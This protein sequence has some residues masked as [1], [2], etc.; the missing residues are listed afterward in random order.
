MASP[1]PHCPHRPPCPGCPHFFEPGYPGDTARALGEFAAAADLAPPV[2]QEGQATGFRTRARLMVRGR[3]ASPKIGIFQSRSHRIA[4]IPNC[5]VHHPLIN[6]VSRSVKQAIRSTD[7]RPY[8]EGPHLGD[9]RAIQIAVERSSQSAQLVLIGN[10][11]D[12]EPLQPL[13]TQLMNELGDDLHSLWWNGNPERSNVILGP[14]WSKVSGPEAIEEEIG[15][16]TIC[17]PPGAFAQSNLDLSDR[18]VSRIAEWVPDNARIAEFYAGC[19]AIGLGLL[20]RAERVL[21][22]EVSAPSLHGL[23]LGIAKLSAAAQARA[24]V[25]PGS[26]GERCELIRDADVVIADP[27]R[28][29]LDPALLNALSESPPSRFVYLSCGLDSFLRDSQ[30]LLEVGKMR[31]CHLE[32]FSLF[33][34]SDHVENLALFES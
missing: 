6:R 1:A 3:S 26:A 20:Q 25:F 9:L 19:G 24:E 2:L 33:R 30:R 10:N 18:I 15:G 28:K 4:D 16:A 12:P 31:L 7:T 11:R 27:P 23:D 5:L 29:G 22:N 17:F 21:F 34:H 13:A 14:H 32:S 8:S